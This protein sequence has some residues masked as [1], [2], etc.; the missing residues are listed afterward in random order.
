[1]VI[2]VFSVNSAFSRPFLLGGIRFYAHA[3]WAI[4]LDECQDGNGLC[5][6]VS[7]IMGGP[8]NYIGY[9]PESDLVL[10][11]INKKD[12]TASSITGSILKIDEDSPID[13]K[14]IQ[15]I[16]GFK[17]NGKIVILKKG[18]YQSVEDANFN[19]FSVGYFLK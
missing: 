13:P 6:Q 12:Q 15:M 9:E 7:K 18:V 19:T 2:L 17:T 8:D 1:M 4:T 14:I 11:K 16:T 3:K 10:I 5:A